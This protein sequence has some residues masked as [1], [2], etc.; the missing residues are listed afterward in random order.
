MSS[1]S[2][3]RCLHQLARL[4]GV[5]TAYYDVFHRRQQASSESILAILRSLGAA[6]ARFEDIPS[7]YRERRQALWQRILEPVIVAWDNQPSL[8]KIRLPLGDAGSAVNCHLKLATGEER[9]YKWRRGD[10]DIIE[11]A[12]VEGVQYAVKQLSL[13][14]YLPPGY[15]R[16]IVEILGRSQEALLISARDRVYMPPAAPVTGTWGVFFPLYSLGTDDNWGAGDFSALEV[17]TE[18]AAGMGGGVIATLPLLASFL[19]NICEPSPYLPASRLLWNEFY[20]DVYKVPE[21]QRCPSAKA[22]LESSSFRKDIESLRRAPLVDY[23]RHMVLKKRVLEELSCHFFDEPSSGIDDFHHFTKMNPS[24]EDYARFRAACE[25]QQSPWRSWPQPLR[26]GVLKE[27]DYDDADRRYHLYVQ[28]L[29][30]RQMGGV[31]KTARNNCVQLYLDLPVGV[32]P[33]GYDVWRERDA[34]VLDTSAGAPPD[35]VFTRGQNW[36]FPP[37]HPEKIR[38]Q[39]Y[40]YVIAYLRHHLRHA[41]ILRIDHVMGLH[42]LFCIPSSTEASQGVYLHYRA[43]ELYAILSLESNYHKT[44]IVGEDLGTVPPYV[45]RSMRKHGL[46]R[47][48]V[49]HYELA[50]EPEK[51]LPPVPRDSVTSLNTHDMP[52]FA[53]FWQSLDIEERLKLGLLGRADARREKKNFADMKKALVDFLQRKGWLQERWENIADVIKACL[54]F[55]AASQ[56]QIVLVNL[57]D[58]WLETRPH[59]VPSTRAEYPNWQRKARYTLEEFAQMPQVVDTLQTINEIRRKT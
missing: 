56:T 25:K 42:R 29:A 46:H 20:L 12:E 32:H 9:I 15:H 19:N 34:F 3:I 51:G 13:S 53:S 5:Q 18:W 39:E 21:L 8:I 43:E 27:T 10:A 49:M 14:G 45:R 57:E 52:P 22:L 47:M 7:T 23:H 41:G 38:E 24:V 6:I 58:L 2:S 31:L 16:L 44:V 4:Y 55:L 11:T 17:L 30:H 48:Y 40:R 33:D 50:S 36:A 26:D 54:S 35:A 28:W 59:N 37:L 1:L